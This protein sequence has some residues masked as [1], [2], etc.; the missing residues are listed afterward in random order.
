MNNSDYLEVRALIETSWKN[1]SFL[2][3]TARNDPS[4]PFG[5]D[6]FV[7]T[8]AGD[9]VVTHHEAVNFSL[10]GAVMKVFGC[11]SLLTKEAGDFLRLLLAQLQTTMPQYAFLQ[12]WEEVKG[13][14][15]QDVLDLLDATF[16]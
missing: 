16:K 9:V 10:P 12:H 2:T 13:R 6:T 8:K 14:S 15:K 4:G 5:H 3:S 11:K 7:T 1:M